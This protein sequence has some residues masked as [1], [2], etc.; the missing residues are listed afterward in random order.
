MFALRPWRVMSAGYTVS[1]HITQ[2]GAA[3]KLHRMKKE[4]QRCSDRLKFAREYDHYRDILTDI[5]DNLR[6]A[7]TGR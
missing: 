2:R 7:R 5:G 4:L 6:I 3:S 1:C